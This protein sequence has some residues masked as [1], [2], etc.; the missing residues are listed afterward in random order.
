M[1][2]GAIWCHLQLSITAP[3][4][5]SEVAELQGSVATSSKCFWPPW[6]R[7]ADS[8]HGM[9]TTTRIAQGCKKDIKRI[10]RWSQ[11]CLSCACARSLQSHQISTDRSVDLLTLGPGHVTRRVVSCH[12]SAA[13]IFPQTPTLATLGDHL[14]HDE[15]GRLGTDSKMFET[16]QLWWDN[17]WKI[18]QISL[19]Y[20]WI[21][22]ILYW[23]SAKINNFDQFWSCASFKRENQ[24]N[25]AKNERGGCST[26][27]SAT[28]PITYCVTKL[29]YALLKS[30]WCN[31]LQQAAMRIQRVVRFLDG[32]QGKTP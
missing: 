1:A 2:H 29:C 17:E 30:S 11:M 21:L 3:R 13:M 20:F 22:L 9:K 14:D 31:T 15:I 8:L 25:T 27:K 16:N 26:G 6:S 19:E 18:H 12:E 32:F 10:L 4:Q 24:W 5:L 28:Y 23:W 7:I